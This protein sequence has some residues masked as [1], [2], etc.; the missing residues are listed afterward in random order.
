MKRNLIFLALGMLFILAVLGTL[1]IKSAF[2][3][4]SEPKSVITKAICDENN[5]CEDYEIACEGNSTVGLTPTGSAVQFSEDWEDPRTE[6]QRQI[7]C[8]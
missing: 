6:E 3:E 7:A 5:Y 8:D 1:L 2:A 4:P